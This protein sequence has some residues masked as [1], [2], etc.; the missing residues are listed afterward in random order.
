M[1]D[2]Q[3][4]IWVWL[5][6][7][8]P[9][10]PFARLNGEGVDPKDFSV[11]RW[12]LHRKISTGWVVPIEIDADKI[13]IGAESNPANGWHGYVTLPDWREVGEGNENLTTI[14][15]SAVAEEAEKEALNQI[16]A[17]L[18]KIIEQQGPISTEALRE[19]VWTLI[20]LKMVFEQ[21]PKGIKK[22][23]LAAKL[24]AEQRLDAA[25]LTEATLALMDEGKIATSLPEADL[26]T[27]VAS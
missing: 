23:D 6:K 27:A 15:K 21:E 12:V 7:F 13:I 17:L 2:L 4:N 1:D 25:R 16:K 22:E 8:S 19:E 3:M 10:I 11:P 24:M 20:S 26:W 5:S 9:I 14:L 18:L